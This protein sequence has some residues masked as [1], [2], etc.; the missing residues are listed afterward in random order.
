MSVIKTSR[1]SLQQLNDIDGETQIAGFFVTDSW[2]LGGQQCVTASTGERRFPT[3]GHLRNQRTSLDAIEDFLSQ[4]RIAMAGISRDPA[5]FSMKL[6]EELCGRGYDMV[7]VNPNA[8]NLDGRPCF[9]RVQDIQ[10]PVDAVLLMTSPEATEI[11][12]KD[13]AEAGINQ[14][15]PG[16]FEPI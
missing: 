5:S 3:G 6:F 14:V 8:T 4:K 11:I 7:P 9:A 16:N 10:P 15:G 12:A 13:C 1:R 2:C